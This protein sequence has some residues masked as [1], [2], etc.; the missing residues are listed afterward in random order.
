VIVAGS[1]GSVP[2]TAQLIE[3]VAG[4]P[5]GLVVLPGLDTQTGAEVWDAVA[6]DPGHPQHGL[7]RLLARLELTRDQVAVWPVS[8]PSA[9]PAAPGLAPGPA[10]A[11]RDLRRRLVDLALYPAVAT[12]RWNAEA[13][14]IDPTDAAEAFDAVTRI[15]GPGRGEGRRRSRSF[16]AGPWRPRAGARPW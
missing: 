8:A 10:P 11:G 13:G 7:A 3:V 9:T 12:P 6:E 16:C 5:Q 1:T 4:L 2:A 15:D 14:Q